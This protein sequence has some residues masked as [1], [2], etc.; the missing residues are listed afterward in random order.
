MEY[1]G[2]DSTTIRI[3]WGFNWT[4]NDLVNVVCTNTDSAL[5]F[6]AEL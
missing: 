6:S 5:T 2:A 1:A 3:Q 4:I